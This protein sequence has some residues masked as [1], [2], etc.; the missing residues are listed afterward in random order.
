MLI[1]IVIRTLNE[2]RYLPRLLAAIQS[3]EILGHSVEVIVVDSGSSDGT[4]KIAAQH[5]C[6]IV[7]IAKDD[8]SFGRSLNLG[9]EAAAGAY[10]VFVSGHCVPIGA[11]WLQALCAPLIDGAAD[12]VYGRQVGDDDSHFSERRIFAK[13]FP[14]ESVVPQLGYYCNNANAAIARGT[15]HRYRF[16]EDLTGLEDMDVAKR[17]YLDG[18][19]IGY[20]ADACVFHHHQEAWLSVRRR[21][22]RES[23]AL[24]RIMPELHLSLLDVARYIVSS[25][26]LDWRSALRTKQFRRAWRDIVKYRGMQYWGSYRGNHEHRKLTH[27]QKEIYFYPSLAER[28]GS[29]DWL[30]PNGSVATH[31]SPQ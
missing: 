8:F 6:R 24:R 28:E 30:R 10:L 12:Y 19:R 11:K 9:C 4:I 27:K 1:S 13:Y 26:L 29:D 23:I 25:I 21:F 2:A 31:E 22:E 17:L 7:H 3:Q 16:D 18:G 14:S 15:W 20:V 5:Q